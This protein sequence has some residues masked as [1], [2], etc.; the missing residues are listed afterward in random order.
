MYIY[1]KKPYKS[2]LLF[3][4]ALNLEKN[5]DTQHT[6]PMHKQ[7]REN[8]HVRNTPKTR[9]RKHDSGDHKFVSSR[10]PCSN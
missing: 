8:D 10:L 2:D 4:A 3:F 7:Y 1:I 6:K 5:K 9:L